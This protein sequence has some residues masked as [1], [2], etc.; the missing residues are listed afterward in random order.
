ME[1]SKKGSKSLQE[2][3]VRNAISVE[4]LQAGK[5]LKQ[6]ALSGNYTKPGSKKTAFSTNN[7]N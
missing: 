2:T 6:K 5:K 7:N 1:L 4:H 3:S